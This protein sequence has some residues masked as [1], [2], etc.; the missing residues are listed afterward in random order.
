LVVLGAQLLQLVLLVLWRAQWCAKD[1]EALFCGWQV[2]V[3]D[4]HVVA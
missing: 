4:P 2:L 1:H 3:A